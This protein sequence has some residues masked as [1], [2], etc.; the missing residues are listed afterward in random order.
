VEK[1]LTKS[2]F[3]KNLFVLTSGTVIAQIIPVL[4]A[5]LLTR[6]FS[7]DEFGVL[8]NFMAIV[9]FIA[10]FISGKYELAT[11]LPKRHE[12]AINILSLS[13]LLALFFSIILFFLFFFLG[14]PISSF[15]RADSLNSILWLIPISAF[16]S[17]VYLVF[18]EW[19]IRKK[20]FLILSKNKIT[21]TTGIAGSSLL[22]G[23]IKVPQ[24]LLWGQL[25]GQFISSS[26]AILRV[27]KE[28]RHLFKYVTLRKMKYFSVKYFD[29]VK[30]FM[31]GQF[32]N[33]LSGLL[34]ILL[35]TSKFGLYEVGLFSLSERVLGTPLTFIGNA[36]KDVFKQRATEEYQSNGKCISIYKKA[37][38]TLIVIS[39]MPF[40]ILFISA[41]FL[42]SLFFGQEWYVAG[43]YT[44]IL[45]VMYFI[46]FVAMSIGGMFIIA[47]KQKLEFRWQVLF[48]ALTIIALIA[49]VFLGKIE[50]ILICLCIGKSI[51]YLAHIYFTYNLAKGKI[52][53]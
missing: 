33:T 37:M 7:P 11:I 31:P 6:F 19:C 14:K 52:K 49:G 27:L 43:E 15:L 40:I 22:F 12:E 21:N 51:G 30:F 3:K 50:A 16:L 18:N 5:P 47:E 42:F 41:P 53:K 45:C 4:C 38:L 23:V 10:V 32:I 8:A 17:V 34:P 2:E 25:M 48:L 1:F 24:G 13:C 39:I 35:L 9:A 20:R 29:F 26:L 36:F 28:D 44:R 46:N